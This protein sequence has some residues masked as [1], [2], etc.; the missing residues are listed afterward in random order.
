MDCGCKFKC[1]Y[2]QCLVDTY[3]DQTN[4]LFETHSGE[5]SDNIMN[6]WV[7]QNVNA[8]DDCYDEYYI[9]CD[10]INNTFVQ[11]TI[12]EVFGCTHKHITFKSIN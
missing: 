4:L 6:E 9:N 12:C 5:L 10:I 11:C 3:D 2:H 8:C 1:A 7:A